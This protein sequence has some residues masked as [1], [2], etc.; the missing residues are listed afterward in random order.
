LL[1]DAAIF[2][3]AAADATLSIFHFRRAGLSTFAATIFTPPP[4]AASFSDFRR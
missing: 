4:L 1:S 2:D 3:I